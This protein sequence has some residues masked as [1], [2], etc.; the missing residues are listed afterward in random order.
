MPPSRSA[1]ARPARDGEIPDH[2][3]VNWPKSKSGTR[4]DPIKTAPLVRRAITAC[5]KCR[6]AKVRCNGQQDCQR[7]ISRRLV[8][9]YGHRHQTASPALDTRTSHERETHVTGQ[10]QSQYLLPSLVDF[11]R[12]HTAAITAATQSHT[13]TAS[14][15]AYGPLPDTDMDPQSVMPLG[16]GS[17]LHPT[18]NSLPLK[19]RHPLS[20]GDSVTYPNHSQSVPFDLSSTP[21]MGDT[22]TQHPAYLQDK[23]GPLL[24]NTIDG[25]GQRVQAAITSPPPLAG[26]QTNLQSLIRDPATCPCRVNLMIWVS[27][28]ARVMQDKRPDEVL[29]VTGEVARHCQDIV[30]CKDDEA[31]C[32]D[33]L[34]IMSVLQET[35]PC[36]DFIAKSG[37]LEGQDGE[38]AVKLS[39]GGYEIALH[40]A[41]VRAMLVSDLVQRA[42]AVVT[43]I[44]NKGQCMINELAEP[45]NL[46]R[47]NVA[48]LE[49]NISNFQSMLAC[50]TRHVQEATNKDDG[51]PVVSDFLSRNASQC[52][53]EE[54]AS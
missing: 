15:T 17:A 37:F 6:A 36:F 46:A 53:T 7:C 5:E 25:G 24:A 35:R 21:Y 16:W 32:S 18:V 30:D 19:P 29:K 10:V 40:N 9:S 42:A 43:S 47:A 41:S 44:G 38:T 28:I 3:I 27:R 14:I 50:V 4:S 11:D 1:R 8:C 2:F 26:L 22:T 54:R 20:D 12:S 31:R 48:Y 13:E 52:P 34:L 23:H 39:F 51:S 49:A 33:L 45:C